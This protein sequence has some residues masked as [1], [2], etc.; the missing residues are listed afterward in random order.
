LDVSHGDLVFR[1]LLGEFLS[2]R[3]FTLMESQEEVSHL[4]LGSVVELDVDISSTTTQ[5]GGVKL[6]LVVSGHEED[7]SLLRSYS[8]QSVEESGERDSSSVSAGGSNGSSLHKDGVDIFQQNNRF[9]RGVVEA[10]VKAIVIKASTSQVQVAD[11]VVQGS[12]YGK[13][14]GSFASSRRSVE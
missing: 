9:S 7:T 5:E 1:K 6:L 12:S 14:E 3:I 11:A 2:K 13:S 10:S 8:I 4:V